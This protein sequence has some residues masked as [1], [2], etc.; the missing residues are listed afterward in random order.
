VSGRGSEPAPAAGEPRY[1]DALA[2][3]ESILASL[4]G[5]AVDV[6]VLAV[7]VRRAAELVR[8]CRAR[9]ATARIEVESVVAELDGIEPGSG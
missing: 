9:L 7:K 8:I 4:E 5:D 6:D 3:L 2:E 1:A